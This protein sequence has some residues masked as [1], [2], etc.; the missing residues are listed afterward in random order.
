MFDCWCDILGMNW[1]ENSVAIDAA[2]R[3]QQEFEATMRTR[4]REVLDGLERENRVGLVLL[5]RP[6]HHDPGLN[7][8]ILNA[9]QDR[10][11]P[12]L[13]QSYL[14]L[15]SDLLDR[16][17]GDELARGVIQSPLEI[18]DVWKNSNSANTNQKI[19]AAKFAAR[20]PNLIPVELSNFKCGHD[21]FVSG[22]IERIVECSGKPYFCFRDLDENKPLA[23][24]NIRIE[25]MDH[26]LKQY[27]SRLADAHPA[28]PTCST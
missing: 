6:Y 17:F 5:G 18:S 23:S 28:T 16:L 12:V 2:L 3:S 27:A 15:D 14:P 1:A 7:Q 4:S 13:S 11:Y 22:V 24:L 25:T 8:G 26:F 20:H 10:G 19:W 9:F 21:A